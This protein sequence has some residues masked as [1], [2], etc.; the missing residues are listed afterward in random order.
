MNPIKAL[1]SALQQSSDARH[2]APVLVAVIL[3]HDMI[4]KNHE[5]VVKRFEVIFQAVD[6][7]HWLAHVLQCLKE[8]AHVAADRIDVGLED[9][10][11]LR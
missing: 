6:W 4:R 5:R 9:W 8:S 11:R 7:F 10:D 1:L 2:I 3:S